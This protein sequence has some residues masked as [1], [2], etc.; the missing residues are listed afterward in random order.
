MLWSNSVFEPSVEDA[1]VEVV[2]ESLLEKLSTESR[3]LLV[4]TCR[5]VADLK[6]RD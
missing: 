3:E 6:A 1:E 2:V 4:I 5:L